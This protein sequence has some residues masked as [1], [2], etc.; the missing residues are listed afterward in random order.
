M[1][2]ALSANRIQVHS[3]DSHRKER[4]GQGVGK[5]TGKWRRTGKGEMQTEHDGGMK[6]E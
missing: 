6:D 5:N 3:W 2:P 1:D 4:Q